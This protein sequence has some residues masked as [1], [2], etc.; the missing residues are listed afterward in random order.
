ME[1]MEVTTSRFVLSV[2]IQTVESYLAVCYYNLNHS[3]IY[4]VALLLDFCVCV[5]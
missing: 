4:A 5:T 1:S 2:A 3:Y